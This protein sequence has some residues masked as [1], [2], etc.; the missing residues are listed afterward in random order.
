[1][2]EG[3]GIGATRGSALFVFVEG[4]AE[5]RAQLDAAIRTVCDLGEVLR[6]GALPWRV[7]RVASGAASTELLMT[8]VRR[9]LAALT[10]A[11]LVE[12]A[13]VASEAGASEAVVLVVLVG[14]I[15]GPS[16]DLRLRGARDVPPWFRN[17][18][19]R[20][21]TLSQG[22]ESDRA[23]DSDYPR[24]IAGH[25]REQ[26]QLVGRV[27]KRSGDARLSSIHDRSNGRS[28]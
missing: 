22:E 8:G 10:S 20:G 6:E 21:T 12:R 17:A 19:R 1:M 14:P 13:G 3:V 7:A 2:T 4:A 16:R 25:S 27:F 9:E 5:Q 28:R 18:H 15:A 23:D 11:P 24:P 26:V